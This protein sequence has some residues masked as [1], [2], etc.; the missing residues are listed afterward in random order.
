[1]DDIPVGENEKMTRRGSKE[2]GGMNV[3]RMVKKKTGTK[4]KKKRRKM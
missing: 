2:S 4:E 1:L 3:K